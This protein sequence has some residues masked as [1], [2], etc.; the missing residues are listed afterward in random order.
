[1]FWGWT[2]YGMLPGIIL[3]WVALVSGPTAIT[4]V[5][6]KSLATRYFQQQS[7]GETATI[8]EVYGADGQHH[9]TWHS[10]SPPILWFSESD[11]ILFVS[12]KQDGY[13]Y[14]LGDLQT[15]R[16]YRVSSAFDSRNRREML[17]PGGRVLLSCG[18]WDLD[19]IVVRFEEIALSAS[20]LRLDQVE[21]G[22][23]R[24][25][26]FA[27]FKAG[28]S[29]ISGP[30]SIGWV[31]FEER[32]LS[33]RECG[34]ATLW[35]S[36]DG[37]WVAID[38]DYVYAGDFFPYCTR[39]FILDPT[40]T[41]PLFEEKIRMERYTQ[42][43]ESGQPEPD[44][45]SPD[46]QWYATPMDEEQ[47]VRPWDAQADSLTDVGA[48]SRVGGVWWSPDSKLYVYENEHGLALAWPAG[49]RRQV[50]LGPTWRVL[51]WLGRDLM[52]VGPYLPDGWG[53]GA[54][55]V[56][57]SPAVESGHD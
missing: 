1:M 15:K 42:F 3:L 14:V 10:G 8:L 45:V 49:W 41:Y 21:P 17:M 4:T 25:E 36:R 23:E 35:P 51:G 55:A 18:Y 16:V 32:L 2:L 44:F 5:N 12:P 28:E 31:I 57:P 46:G 19:C 56:I 54:T 26:K 48:D 40:G 24:D 33:M 53:E 43:L 7:I 39:M 47:S 34:T 20:R 27:H 30:G 11:R 50:F 37:K 29:L 52:V 22:D 13:V 6:T 9:V 38:F